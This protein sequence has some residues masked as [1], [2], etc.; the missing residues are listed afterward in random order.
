MCIFLKGSC[1]TFAFKRHIIFAY[2]VVKKRQQVVAIH[3]YSMLIFAFDCFCVA[4]EAKIMTLSSYM[5][6]SNETRGS[7][8]TI[9]DIKI[10]EL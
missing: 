9:N 2:L 6:A 3:I 1:K 7:K 5:Y 8:G 10:K 4:N